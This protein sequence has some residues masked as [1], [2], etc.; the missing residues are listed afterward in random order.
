M[1][2]MGGFKPNSGS[3]SV[4]CVVDIKCSV[5]RLRR[6][7]DGGCPLSS[8]T[9]IACQALVWHP[10]MSQRDS[11]ISTISTPNRGDKV[12]EFLLPSLQASTLSTLA[13]ASV[14]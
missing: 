12:E 1:E 4:K 10:F 3:L 13:N 6:E 11:M 7:L 8:F 9:L 5:M 2:M 14:E